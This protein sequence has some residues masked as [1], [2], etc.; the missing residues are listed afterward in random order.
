MNELA[1]RARAA[2]ARGFFVGISN[3][4]KLH[5]LAR[6]TAHGVEVTHD[7]RY[8]A[9]DDA[10]HTLDVYRPTHRP[11]PWPIVFYVHGGGF[12]MLSK[13]THWV[14]GLAFARQGYLTVAMNYRLVPSAPYPAGLEDVA[15]AYRWL[16]AHAGE[17]GGD[18]TRIAVAGES[19]GAN[20]GVALA[21]LMAR[22][23]PAEAGMPWAART[24]DEARVPR[25][26]LPY[27]GL[28]QVSDP[29][30]FIRRR[31]LPALVWDT[32]RST[33]EGYTA[34]SPAQVDRALADPLCVLES[35]AVM[36]RPLPPFFATVGTRDPLL[37]DTR[38]LFAA[39]ERRDVPCEA[40]YYPG[41]VHAFHAFVWQPVAQ[42]CWRDSYAFLD[43]AMRDGGAVRHGATTG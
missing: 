12:R 32:I 2:I 31:A 38:R 13:D 4:A 42:R 9:S 11:G 33:A 14:M 27:G 23:T 17:L 34:G 26:V 22:R 41:G 18:P 21:V 24:F 40:R 20:L 36:D 43:A 8:L 25:A 39:L 7:V 29:E 15:A 10:A 3:A 19:A 37:D 35:D 6:P 1:S 5:P 30:R 16:C 28:L